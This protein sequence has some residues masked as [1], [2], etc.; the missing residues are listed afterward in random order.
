MSYFKDKEDEVLFSMHAVF[1]IDEIRQNN[2][3]ARLFEV[4][5][6]L[7]NDDDKDLRELTNRIRSE[8]SPDDNGW[9]RLCYLLLRMGQASKAQEV[10]E[11]LLEESSDENERGRIYDG[12][13]RAHDF[14]GRYKEA[15]IFHEKSLAIRQQSFPPNHP[16]LATSYN[17]LG[18]V[19]SNMGDYTK[20]LSSYEKALTIYPKSLPPN[21]P[22]LATPYNNLGLVFD[23]MGDYAK[24]LSSYEKVL[25]IRQQSL[26][27]NHPDLAAS[28]NNIGSVYYKMG[29]YTKA[30][31]SYEKGLAIKQQ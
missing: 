1:R 3:N 7:T 13:G 16:T 24:A 2:E 15:I 19:Y 14:Q 12:L 21:H 4:K 8:T 26:P 25:T 22:S 23:N 17:N 10:Y 5:L 6:T 27:T 11:I 18:L 29:D 28:Y 9:F 20:A 31:S 30:L